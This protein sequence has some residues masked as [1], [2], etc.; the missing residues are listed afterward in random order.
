[1]KEVGVFEILLSWLSYRT[2]GIVARGNL[3]RWPGN[4]L[5]RAL[6]AR[7]RCYSIK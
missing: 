2:V 3:K 1:M 4:G 6:N 7:L 5:F